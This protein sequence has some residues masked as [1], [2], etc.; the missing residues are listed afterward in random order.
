MKVLS[1]VYPHGTYEGEIHLRGPGVCSS[2]HQRLSEDAGI[3]IIH[4]ELALVPAALDRREHLPR[5]RAGQGRHH[6]L[7]QDQP[8]QAERAAA[9]VGLTRT[10]T[11]RSTKIGVG[12]QQLVEIAKALSKDVKLLILDEPTAALNED[13]S[14]HLLDLMLVSC[15]A[16]GHHLDHDLA[17]AQR[18]RR[19]ADS[20]TVIR[21]G[22]TDRDPRRGPEM[23][24][25]ASSGD[26]RPR[27]GKPLPAPHAHIGERSSRSRT[28]R[29]STR[30]SRAQGHQERRPSRAPG[31]IVG[32]A[33]LMGAG[34]TELAMSIFGAATASTARRRAVR[35]TASRSMS[36][37]VDRGHRRG[38]RLRDRGPQVLRPEPDRRHQAQHARP[39]AE[40]DRLQA[41]V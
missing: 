27:P 29:S 39:I 21:D 20:I 2:R 31:E 9:R 12:K 38:P 23:T 34:R 18:D 16:A 40:E 17:Q 35:C 10:P 24:R 28:G 13:D 11:P 6:R 22:K 36:R 32:I 30:P 1:G 41:S 4:Q 14:A 25:T 37:T 15:K 33:G 8:A 19:I 7:E 5:Q 26:G 3:V